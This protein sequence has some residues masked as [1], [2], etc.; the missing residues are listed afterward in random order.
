M[1]FR[2]RSRRH[3]DVRLSATT[4]SHGSPPLPDNRARE[5]HDS[6]AV[7]NDR[8]EEDTKP[9]QSR[10]PLTDSNPEGQPDQHKKK[11]TSPDTVQNGGE[12]VLPQ[13]GVFGLTHVSQGVQ[14]FDYRRFSH[15]VPPLRIEI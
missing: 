15:G 2:I 8:C 5:S 9:R 13:S 3:N 14:S 1:N 10:V 4:V 7:S 6:G 11:D 12:D